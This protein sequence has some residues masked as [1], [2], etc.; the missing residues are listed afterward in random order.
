ME[1]QDYFDPLTHVVKPLDYE[2][3]DKCSQD[4][5]L[6]QNLPALYGYPVLTQS[7]CGM[8]SST[9]KDAVY[10]LSQEPVMNHQN[11]DSHRLV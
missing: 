9:Y 8:A 11:L 10:T 4:E 3:F 1:N 7:D 5:L 6:P 2:V